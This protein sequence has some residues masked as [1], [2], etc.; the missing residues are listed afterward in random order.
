[1]FWNWSSRPDGGH[2]QGAL[3]ATG[4]AWQTCSESEAAAAPLCFYCVQATATPHRPF[5]AYP[6]GIAGYT[7]GK[8][9]ECRT[10]Q[11]E[12]GSASDFLYEAGRQKPNVKTAALP[13]CLGHG[14]GDAWGGERAADPLHCPGIDSELFGNDAHTGPPRSRQS[15]ADSLFECRS[16]WG[17][18]EAFTLTPG[19]RK[20]GTD[21]FRNH[22]PLVP[23]SPAA[24]LHWRATTF[25][26]PW[27]GRSPNSLPIVVAST[28]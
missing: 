13:Q 17:T 7:G 22:R 4:R 19:P 18:P 15:L 3:L 20:A 21:S 27:K 11:P 5:W 2:N 9:C 10:E 1:V 28:L 14:G 24:A 12:R 23:A 8:R 16:N 25:A 6:E 26:P